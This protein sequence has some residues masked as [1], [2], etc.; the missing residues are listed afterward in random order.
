MTEV[1]S[2]AAWYGEVPEPSLRGYLESGSAVL[3]QR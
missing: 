2:K 1:G 3:L